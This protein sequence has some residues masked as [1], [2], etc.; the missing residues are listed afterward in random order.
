MNK[1]QYVL[2]YN[3]H[4]YTTFIHFYL[5]FTILIPSVQE[6]TCSFSTCVTT[7]LH[8]LC[9]CSFLYSPSFPCPLCLSHQVSKP[10]QLLS[11]YIL[12]Q[13]LNFWLKSHHMISVMSCPVI[14]FTFLKNFPTP[15]NF[16]F[17]HSV[18]IKV[19]FPCV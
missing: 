4:W 14:Y 15:C 12:D 5:S 16:V 19:S 6:M 11:L 7:S 9:T 1:L 2:L 17:K 18:R 13:R 10:L 3:F 8:V